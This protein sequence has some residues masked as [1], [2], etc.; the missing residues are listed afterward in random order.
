[1]VSASS[2]D[3]AL[4]EIERQQFDLLVTDQRMPGM[5]GLELVGKVQERYPDTQFI[6]ITAYGSED[7]FDEIKMP[8]WLKPALG[9][10]LLG[11]ILL[12]WP[13]VFGVGRVLGALCT[14]LPPQ[15]P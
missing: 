10:L 9:G 2:T 3:E 1:M 15:G 14:L 5:T 11:L 7:L 13:Q 4:R 8:E 12:K 6:L